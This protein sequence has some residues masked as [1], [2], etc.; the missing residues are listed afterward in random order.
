M[1]FF[2]FAQKTRRVHVLK[3][4][5]A[6]TTTAIT[7]RQERMKCKI[8]WTANV[9]GHGPF[10]R[11]VQNRYIIRFSLS[12]FLHLSIYLSSLHARQFSGPVMLQWISILILSPTHAS[13]NL[14]Y[15]SVISIV[16]M[17]AKCNFFSLS[18]FGRFLP[19]NK[20]Y[21]EDKRAHT[22]RWLFSFKPNA[23]THYRIW[24]HAD[25][26][27][28]GVTYYKVHIDLQPSLQPS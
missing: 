20:E 16:W 23:H 17:C 26:C 22:V 13:L 1:V 5:T 25:H 27:V 28:T 4:R 7:N 2:W 15:A 11:S 21:D 12:L 10:E 9:D 8:K 3:N 6:T 24:W 18:L 19:Q 14:S